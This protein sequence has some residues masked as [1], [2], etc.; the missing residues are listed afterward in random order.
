[1]GSRRRHAG[2]VVTG[3]VSVVTF[4][5]CN[6][7]ITVPEA[8]GAAPPIQLSIAPGPYTPGQTYY[9]TNDWIEYH[10]GNL[11]IVILAPHGGDLKPASIPDRTAGACGGS[12]TTGADTNTAELARSLKFRFYEY[13]GKYPH[14]IINRLHRSKLDANRNESEGACGNNNAKMAWQD[15]HAFINLAKNNVLNGS[16]GRGWLI[17]VHGHGHAIQRV[18]LGYL[19]TAADLRQSDATLNTNTTYRNKSSFRTFATN[20]PFNFGSG[21][22]RGNKAIGTVLDQLGFPS[23][24]SKQDPAPAEGEPY[25]NGGYNTSTHGCRSGGDICGLQIE[26][27]YTGIRDTQD[28]RKSFSEALVRATD[29]F[30]G[31]N[32]ELSLWSPRGEIVVD[33]YNPANDTTKAVFSASENWGTYTDNA[34][35]YLVNFRRAT[36]AGPTNDGASFDF[37]IPATGSYSVYARW[38]ASANRSTAVRYRVFET[39]GGTMFYNADQ[40]QRA[41][42]GEWVLLGTWNWTQTGWARVLISRS[43][44]GAGELAADAIRVVRN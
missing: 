36:G 23:V 14:V 27:Y 32:F 33:N 8:P 43:L 13:T 4:A 37:K 41:N 16:W 11:P 29:V 28:N 35:K 42:G 18:E 17:D 9:S 39:I 30:L 44:S 5:A 24:P 15:F 21:L 3:L 40:N 26:T 10:A 12:A 19:L 31:H 2:W 7:T 25:F 6:D 38:P 34:G 1:M 20:S 22:L